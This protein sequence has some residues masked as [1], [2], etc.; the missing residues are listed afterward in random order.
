MFAIVTISGKQY[1]VKKGDQIKVAN[2]KKNVGDKIK[3]EKVLLIEDSNTLTVG[4][5]N[6]N[7]S[8]VSGTVLEN[9]RD[10]KIIIFKK[11]R[12]KGYR[13]K[14]GHRQ[15]FSL[16]QI[17]SI[18]APKKKAAPKKSTKSKED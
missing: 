5:P 15:S 4:D 10:R 13:R 1:R 17:D 11:K 8:T 9:G 2:L 14:N 3:F 12:R 16:V 18:T 7:G 6:I